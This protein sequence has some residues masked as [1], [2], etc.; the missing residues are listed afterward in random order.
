VIQGVSRFVDLLPDDT[1]TV[2]Q[3]VPM[4]RGR[5]QLEWHRGHRTL[6]LEFETPTLIHYLKYD[7]DRAIEEESTLP[8]NDTIRLMELLHWF[9]EE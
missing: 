7:Q 3:I 6:E 1:I 8:A 2:P 5:L 4:T 9:H